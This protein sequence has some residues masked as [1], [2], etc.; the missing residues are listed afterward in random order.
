MSEGSFTESVVE[1]AALAWLESLGYAVKHGPV[2][3]PGGD[4]LTLALSQWERENYSEV[5]LGQRLR[6]A[7]ARLNAALPG[8]AIDDAFRKVT[9]LEGATL[10]ARNRTFHRLLVDGVTVEYRSDGAI[11]GAQARLIDRQSGQ[12]RLARRQSIHRR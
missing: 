8:E 6:Q 9:R 3:S 11:R 7:L 12:Q 5:I 1:E 2:I 4:A 10:D